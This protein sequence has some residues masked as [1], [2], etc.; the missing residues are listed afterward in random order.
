MQGQQLDLETGLFYNRFRYYCP[1]L[2]QYVTQDP[3]GFSGGLNAYSFAAGIPTVAVD[4]LGLYASQLGFY[5]HQRAGFLVFGDQISQSELS[6]IARGQEWA[7]SK[8]NQTANRSYMHAMRNGDTNETRASACQ[9]SNAFIQKVASKALAEKR[10]GNMHH[11]LFYFA[12]ALHTMQDST[13]PS[14]RGF[15]PWSDHVGKE[16]ELEHV[17]KEMIYPGKGSDLDKI[18]QRAWNG[19]VNRDLKAFSISCPCP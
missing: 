9:K 1:G 8:I 10:K 5:V 6:T 19:F 12:V 17:T 16:E 2:G 4:P 18:T 13:S 7:D 15:Q 11:A 14:H 3:I